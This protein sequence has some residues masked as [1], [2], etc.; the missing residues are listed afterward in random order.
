M[1]QLPDLRE[2][3]QIKK[4]CAAD[5]ELFSSV[6]TRQL[7]LQRR[8]IQDASEINMPTLGAYR[9]PNRKVFFGL[10]PAPPMR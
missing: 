10:D 2:R 8:R 6:W 1:V 9:H 4:P 7:V 3:T 5:E